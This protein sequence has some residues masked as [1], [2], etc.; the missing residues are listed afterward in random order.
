MPRLSTGSMRIFRMTGKIDTVA[1][2]TNPIAR[3]ERHPAISGKEL[4]I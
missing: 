4:L 2:K 3:S 1:A